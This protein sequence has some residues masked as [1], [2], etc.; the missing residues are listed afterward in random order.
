MKSL[1]ERKV[2]GSAALKLGDVLEEFDDRLGSR[3]EPEILTLTE[4]M[5]F[6]S[7]RER[8]NKR[9]AIADTSDYRFIGLN[10][11]AF[12]PYLLW[13]GAV[14]Q[15]TGWKEAIISP[16]YPTFHVRKK[17]N[18]RFVN[19]LLC[20]GF[21]RERADRRTADLI[22]AVFHEMFGDPETNPLGWPIQRAGDLMAA[23]EYGTS[24]KANEKGRGIVVLRMGNVTTDGRLDLTDLKTVELPDGELRKQR[25]QF[26]D[27][28]FNRTNSRELVGK[29]G[30][31]DGRFEAV[32][33]SYFI[34]VRFRTDREHPLHFTAFMN[35][36]SMKRRLA[37]IAR[38]A[39]GQ[40]NINSKEL[41]SIEVPVPP[42]PLQQKF[43][44]R[45]AAIRELEAGQAAIQR[46]LEGL[47]QS[48][49]HRAFEGE[50]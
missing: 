2:A 25:L 12:N 1:H 48:L 44:D 42:I 7:Q 45:I 50:L 14:A 43:A 3:P 47:F 35:L 40:A 30:M 38:G 17:Y 8:F 20:S 29:T 32:P 27:V 4:K 34:R 46:H 9:L 41:Q 15:N 22:P 33:A 21:L 16:V 5:G 28:L 39:V 24:Q 10:D 11:I 31:W 19:Y 23:C 13:A 26:G 6:V 36:P 37:A 18:P 49:Q